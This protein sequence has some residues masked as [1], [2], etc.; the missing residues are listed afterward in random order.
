MKSFLKR[1]L[2]G[3]LTLI[4]FC[5]Y[6]QNEVSAISSGG[7]LKPVQANMDVRHYTLALNVDPTAEAINGYTEIDVILARATDSLLF[8]LIKKY[9]VTEITV[10][11]IKATFKHDNDFIHIT[12]KSFAAG[13]HKIKISYSGKPP[14]AVK[15]PWEGGFT[16]GKDKAGNPWIAINDQLQGAKVYFPCKDHPSDEAN[17]GADLII[18]VPKGLVV[19]GPGLLQKVTSSKDKATY[20]WKTNYTI[21]NYCILFN[22]GKYKVV[23]RS[24]KT[25]LGNTVPIEFYV[26]EEEDVADA[27]SV[28]EI[29]ERDTH[30]LEKYFG[31]YPWAKEKIGIAQVNNPGMEHQT[32]ITYGD[33]FNYK[34]IGGINYSDNLWHEFAHEWW[35]NKVTNKDW[36]H[37]W[38]QEGI[39]TYSESLFFRDQFGEDAYDSNMYR[40]RVGI[41]N[42]VPVVQGEGLSMREIYN[43]DIYSKGAF[44]MNTLRYVLGDSVF[45]PALKKFIV[46]TNPANDFYV[47]DDVKNFFNHETGKDLSPLF[48][49]YLLTTK[50]MDFTLYRV[51]PSVYYVRMEN[52]PMASLPLDILTDKGIVHITIGPTNP[53]DAPL[54]IESKTQPVIDPKE[55]Y[56][57]KVITQ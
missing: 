54:K 9:T 5:I 57:K 47:T 27:Q 52:I 56:F 8:D 1:L 53:K 18:T 19:A 14:V 39:C 17:E 4:V 2:S 36:A 42:K 6:A 32:M 43:N 48:D 12:G 13:K 7:K 31:E 3:L 45:F 21:S 51:E 50:T 30:I 20:H 44:F 35:A 16:W 55:R 49:Q 46:K 38:I 24:Y 28:L 23:S 34:K 40:V 10:D 33:H 25:I 37:M 26:L 11:K 29:R 41:Q 22:I 15:P